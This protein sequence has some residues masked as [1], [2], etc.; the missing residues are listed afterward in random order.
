MSIIPINYDLDTAGAD[1]GHFVA[2]SLDGLIFN[3]IFGGGSVLKALGP[4]HRKV[5]NFLLIRGLPGCSVPDFE[6][7]ARL[8]AS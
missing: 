7:L 3:F 1:H 6:V 8:G 4:R 5:V 2:I